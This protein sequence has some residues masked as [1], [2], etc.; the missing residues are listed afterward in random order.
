MQ[1]YVICL[2]DNIRHPEIIVLLEVV[3]ERNNYN[4]D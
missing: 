2:T 4:L 1:V 3:F